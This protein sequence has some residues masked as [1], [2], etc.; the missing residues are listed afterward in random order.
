VK[1][2]TTFRRTIAAVSLLATAV[3]SVISV[4]LAPEFVSGGREQ[5][6]ALDE[7]GASASVSLFAFALAQLPFIAAVLA[8][9]HLLRGR[10]PLLSNL[11]ATLGVIG[12]FGHAVYAGVQLV[13][14]A[15]VAQG[16]DR[17]AYGAVLDRMQSGPAMTFAAMGLLG[18][19]LGLL[20]LAIGLWRGSVGPRWM[21]AGLGA[22]LVVEFVGASLTEWASLLAGAI[23]LAVFGM[24]ALIVWR[25]TD[26]EWD[27]VVS[28]P[29]AGSRTSPVTV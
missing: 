23:Y 21:P 11:G 25:T 5:L 2:P 8:V 22:F 4:I 1:N 3:L 20:L 14:L 12:A 7:A 28:A 6:D 17:I 26:A 10:T 19:V 27:A 18:T 16:G 13:A 29:A 9:A 15:M 24:L